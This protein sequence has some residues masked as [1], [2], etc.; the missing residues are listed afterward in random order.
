MSNTN[1]VT[2][3]TVETIETAL[4]AAKARKAKSKGARPTPVTIEERAAAKAARDAAR[5]ERQAAKAKATAARKPAHLAKVEKA[6][7]G[8]PNLTED[9]SGI[10]NSLVSA[11]P[12]D[13]LLAL[14]AHLQQHVRLQRT[15]QATAASA[16]PVAGNKVRIVSGDHRFVGLVGT[17]DRA[18]RIR[19]YVTLEGRSKPLYL[20][21]S[22]VEVVTE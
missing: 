6:L 15:L 10:Y 14:A 3:A 12:A 20:F 22:D 17:V 16:R 11:Q 8:L 5:A 9:V 13:Q 7:A 19:C 1:V 2:E 21:T 4:A 18:Q